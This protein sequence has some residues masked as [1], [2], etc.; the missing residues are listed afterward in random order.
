MA[1]SIHL[2]TFRVFRVQGFYPTWQTGGRVM[3][4]KPC[5][6]TGADG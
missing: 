4:N 2:T 6:G 1:L 3:Q 5:T